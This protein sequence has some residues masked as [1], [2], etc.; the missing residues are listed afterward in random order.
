MAVVEWRWCS[1][2]DTTASGYDTR[3][4]ESDPIY[5]YIRGRFLKGDADEYQQTC[6]NVFVDSN[7]KCNIE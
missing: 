7:S 4:V 6:L 2:L 5:T 1:A 3:Y